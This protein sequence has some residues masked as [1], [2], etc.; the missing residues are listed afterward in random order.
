MLNIFVIHLALNM[1]NRV[2]LIKKFVNFIKLLVNFI[3]GLFLKCLK[4]LKNKTVKSDVTQVTELDESIIDG[5]DSSLSE[6]DESIV[7]DRDSSLS[8]TTDKDSEIEAEIESIKSEDFGD[9][10]TLIIIIVIVVTLFAIWPLAVASLK[11]GID[12]LNDA[13]LFQ[14]ASCSHI[15]HLGSVNAIAFGAIEIGMFSSIVLIGIGIILKS[16]A[17]MAVHCFFLIIVIIAMFA[18]SVFTL[19][20]LGLGYVECVGVSSSGAIINIL[21]GV[22]VSVRILATIRYSFQDNIPDSD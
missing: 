9:I 12:N 11:I 18:Q 1:A 19:V 8:E 17:I 4:K 14:N 5:T 3:L 6:S 2:S 21:I 20:V 16:V 22:T 10:N 7:N 15:A 13:T